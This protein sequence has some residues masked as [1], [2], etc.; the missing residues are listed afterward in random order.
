MS[1]LSLLAKGGTK[2]LGY[3]KRIA[4]VTPDFLLGETSQVI[5]GAMR[6]TKGSLFTKGRAGFR[7]LESHVATQTAANGNFFARA[8]K[9]LKGTKGAVTTGYKPA[10]AT[11]KAAACAYLLLF[12]TTKLSKVYL[13]LKIFCFRSFGSI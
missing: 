5:G 9:S 12:P 6:S 11:A 7:A 10:A 13:G 4:K 3:G 1:L 8:W 2:A